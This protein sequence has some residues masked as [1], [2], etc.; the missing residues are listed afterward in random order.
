MK[1]FR[2]STAVLGATRSTLTNYGGTIIEEHRMASSSQIDWKSI[3]TQTRRGTHDKGHISALASDISSRGL[4]IQPMVELNK[5][6]GKYQILSGHHRLFAMRRLQAENPEE[7]REF[8]CTV[9]SFQDPISRIKFLQACNDHPPVKGH[10]IKDAVWF[11]SRMREEKYF[12]SCSGDVEDIKVKA[13][14]LLTEF[15]P[16]VKS[17]S[18][19]QVFQEAFNNLNLER[20]VTVQT[21]DAVDLSEKLWG[22]ARKLFKWDQDVYYCHSDYMNSKKAIVM[23]LR[24][25]V[26]DINEGKSRR[27]KKGK[28]RLVTFFPAKY[29]VSSLKNQRL[30]ALQEEAMMNNIAWDGSPIVIDQICFAPQINGAKEITEKDCLIYNWDASEGEFALAA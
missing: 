11:L 4:E 15:Y 18:K 23:A 19:R 7:Q 12:A 29:D 25:R 27:A 22:S 13:Y 16:R 24:K 30:Q 20:V 5:T 1:C 28:V 2:Y 8:P 6:S 26:D 14:G 10:S 21:E 3:V 17:V 9:V